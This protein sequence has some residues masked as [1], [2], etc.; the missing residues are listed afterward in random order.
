MTRATPGGLLRALASAATATLAATTAGA[1]EIVGAPVDWRLNFQQSGSGHMTDIHVFHDWLL[2]VIALI[3]A[4][5]L[6]L[7]LWVIVRYRAAANPT[8]GTRSHNT[9]LEVLWTAIPAL[10]LVVIA[11]PSFRI[12]N[13][14]ETVP[15]ADMTVKAIGSQ[16]YWTY[17]YPDHGDFAFDAFPAYD[18]EDFEPGRPFTRLLSTDNALVVPSGR[19]V[20]VLV[21]ANDV[22]HSWTIPA[23]GVKMDAVPG[24]LNETWFNADREGIYYGQCSELCGVNHGQMPIELHVVSPAA[25]DTWVAEAREIHARGDLPDADATLAARDAR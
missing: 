3:S 20:R 24:R 4:F 12:L 25:F 5:V 8:P 2:W 14:A 19:T 17:E 22:L 7:L 1:A 23:L 13:Q 21:T 18:G 9:L 6:L 11:V 16:W 15:P 10:I